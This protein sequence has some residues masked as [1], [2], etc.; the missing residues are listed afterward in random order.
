VPRPI[1]KRV[2]GSGVADIS[3]D[4]WS[5]VTAETASLLIGEPALLLSA[6]VMLTSGVD[7]AVK[8]KSMSLRFRPVPLVAVPLVPL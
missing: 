8:L 2:D 3:L 6:I 5:R 7:V 1:R 4:S